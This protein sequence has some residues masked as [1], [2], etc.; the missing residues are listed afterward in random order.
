MCEPHRFFKQ[1]GFRQ[2]TVKEQE[3]F[4][5]KYLKVGKEMDIA[6]IP[7]SFDDMMDYLEQ[8][9]AKHTTYADTNVKIAHFTMQLFLS[10]FPEALHPPLK[11]IMYAMMDARL[12]AAFHYPDPP[13]WATG[14]VAALSYLARA[15]TRVILPP[16]PISWAAGT[17]H[18]GNSAE[19]ATK[20]HPVF[21]NWRTAGAF[22]V[23]SVYKSYC[24]QDLGTAKPGELGQLGT[25][26]GR[27]YTKT[28]R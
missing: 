2:Y 26:S 16:R 21:F 3:S 27:L 1:H 28:P 15:T 17:T 13:V 19:D 20:S 6:D 18:G 4:Y 25:G 10:D 23:S 12:R 22:A 14:L 9:E 24:I 7:A 8:F 11:S 5:D